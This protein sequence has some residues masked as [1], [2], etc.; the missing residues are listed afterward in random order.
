VADRL[1][2]PRTT[3]LT[4]TE[5][6]EFDHLMGI[7]DWKIFILQ[8]E[9]ERLI[10]CKGLPVRSIK[11][12]GGRTGIAPVI[13]KLAA[14]LMCYL[15]ASATLMSGKKLGINWIRGCAGARVSL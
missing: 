9:T 15:Q 12:Y 3:N 1:W 5:F 8:G 11:A 2:P 7:V 4:P 13:P 6:Y 10:G 14:V